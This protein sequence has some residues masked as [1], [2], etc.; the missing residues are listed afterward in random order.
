M[1]IPADAIMVN[2]VLLGRGI[3]SALPLQC[4]FDRVFDYQAEILFILENVT[5]R[6]SF[7]LFS[8]LVD[9]FSQNEK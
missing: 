7:I 3:V 1:D 6:I 2:S 4:Q 8:I 9:I 5:G